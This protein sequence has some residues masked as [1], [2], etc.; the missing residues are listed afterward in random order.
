MKTITDV[1]EGSWAV[2]INSLIILLAGLLILKILIMI[3]KKVLTKSSIDDALHTLIINSV[4]V[5]AVIVI[6]V[7]VLSELGVNTSTFIA[8]VGAAGA[9]VALALKDSLANV[10]GG[11]I[12]LVT[13]PFGRG[14]YVMIDNVE[15]AVEKIDIL[16]TTLK[17]ADNKV[18]LI[19]NS[20]ISNN[21]LI[22]YTRTDARRVDLQVGVSYDADIDL[23]KSVISNAADSCSQI[24][25]DKGYTIG[26]AAYGESAVIFDVQVWTKPEHYW[27]VKYYLGEKIKNCLEEAEIEIPYTHI[28]VIVKK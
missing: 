25:D 27:K 23:V 19:P 14:D 7:S 8:V 6:T 2:W 10:A 22:N 24:L 28:D 9:A 13:K 21:A 15:G 12:I 11:I 16:N 1:F 26:V 20:I 17:T 18:V 3:I 5:A 4:K